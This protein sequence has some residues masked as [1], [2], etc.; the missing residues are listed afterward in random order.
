MELHKKS[1]LILIVLGII[2][3]YLTL[4]T[5]K[6]HTIAAQHIIEDAQGNAVS[7][8]TTPSGSL[9][10]WPK[11]PGMLQAL[12]K[13]DEVDLFIY[14]YLIKP[15]VLVGLS[16]LMWIVTGLSIFKIVT[17]SSMFK[18][19]KIMKTRAVA[20]FITVWLAAM[21]FALAWGSEFDWPDY[22][23]IDYGFPMVWATHVLSTIAGPVDIWR[24]DITALFINLLFWLGSMVIGVAII[25]RFR[26]RFFLD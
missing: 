24:T 10:P 12:S 1:G 16:I 8:R 23:H 9:F 14:R 19:V 5:T 15:W 22:V 7:W 25:L 6:A 4:Y 11:E 2:S 21:F 26:R 20:Y 13:I 17:S 18:M 3:A